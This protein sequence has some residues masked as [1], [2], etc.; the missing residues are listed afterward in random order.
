M[1]AGWVVDEVG[2]LLGGGVETWEGLGEKEWVLL[3]FHGFWSLEAHAECCAVCGSL[4]G[5]LGFNVT[6]FS[7][8]LT[9]GPPL[10]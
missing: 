6:P 2:W 10:P 5:Q 9:M 8:T 7:A 1:V 4:L 3:M